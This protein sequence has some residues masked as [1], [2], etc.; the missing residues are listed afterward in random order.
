VQEEDV[1]LKINVYRERMIEAIAYAGGLNIFWLMLFNCIAR[2]LVRN[3]FH[4]SLR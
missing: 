2:C 3:Q 4:S 1:E